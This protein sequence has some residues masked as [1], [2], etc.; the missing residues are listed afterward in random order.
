MSKINKFEDIKSWQLAREATKLIFDL[1]SR[2]EFSKDFTLVNQIRRS[3]ISIMSNI[4]EGFERGGDKEFVNFLSIAKGSCGEARS[5]IYIALDRNYITQTEFNS[6]YRKLN[7]TGKLIGGFM[8]YLKQSKLR[9]SKFN[10]V[11]N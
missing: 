9:G 8:N 5:Q 2:Q 6:A 3:S 10:E 4:A 1:S 11:L 7:E